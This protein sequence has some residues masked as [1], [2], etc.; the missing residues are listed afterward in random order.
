MQV[1]GSLVRVHG[2]D[3]PAGYMLAGDCDGHATRTPG[4]LL[5]VTLADCVPIFVAD[6]AR[7]AVALL[8]AGWRGTAGR[9][10]ESGLSA[11][12]EAFGSSPAEV[13][14]HLGPAICGKCYEVGPAVFGAVGE[15]Q[16]AGPACIDL[17]QVIAKQAIAAGVAKE[18]VSASGE[19]TLC[20]GGAERYYSHRGGDRRRHLAFL[21]IAPS[22]GASLPLAGG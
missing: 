22:S 19:C 18:R 12:S 17:R 14:V 6:P 21:G 1:H 10:L 11:M 13:A 3:L 16:P 5:A 20:G 9:V 2:D 15:R 7:R 4:V 8:H